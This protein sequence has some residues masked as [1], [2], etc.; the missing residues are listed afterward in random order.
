MQLTIT[1]TFKFFPYIVCMND[2]ML[3]QFQHCPG[4]R[5]KDFRKVTF[6]HKR[7]AYYINGQL[8]SRIKLER[9]AIKNNY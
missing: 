3:Y 2:G 4:K 5:T 7:K 9:L 6:N 8:V 1:Q